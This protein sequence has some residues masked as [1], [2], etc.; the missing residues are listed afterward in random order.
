MHYIETSQQSIWQVPKTDGRHLRER[1]DYPTCFH[2]IIFKQFLCVWNMNTV[3]CNIFYNII[4][5]SHS[6]K[7]WLNDRNMRGCWLQCQIWVCEHHLNPHSN[8]FFHD[9]FMTTKKKNSS[10]CW[11][12]SYII[13]HILHIIRQYH[14]NKKQSPFSQTSCSSHL[15]MLCFLVLLKT[16]NWSIFTNEWEFI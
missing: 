12:D 14:M 3:D 16:L 13:R 9:N 11:N 10:L 7:K 15:C 4:M 6:T 8:T 5:T 2:Q 1:L